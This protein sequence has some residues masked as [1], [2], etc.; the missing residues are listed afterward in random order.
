MQILLIIAILPVVVYG[1][2]IYNKDKEKEPTSLL[3]RLF[4]GGGFAIVL[5]LVLTSGLTAF[6][7]FIGED[8]SLLSLPELF[9]SIFI[10]VGLVEE[11]S[12]WLFAYLMVF[13]DKEFDESFDAVV[14]C[15]FVALGFACFENILYVLGNNNIAVGLYRAVT[16]VPAH[17]CNGIFMGYFFGLA[18]QKKEKKA[19]YLFLSVLVPTI[20]HGTYDF[21]IFANID[22]FLTLFFCYVAILFVSSIIFLGRLSKNNKKFANFLNRYCSKCGS[23]IV[24]IYCHKCG[25]KVK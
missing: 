23:R 21:I 15:C 9:V 3:F 1:L 24:G 17:L 25:R 8:N 20:I 2:L 22:S 5:T 14:Y 4:M 18:K 13:D 19:F 10:G 16:A 12:K 11:F 7:P 6:I